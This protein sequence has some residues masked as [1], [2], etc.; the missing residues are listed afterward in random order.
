MMSI[1][2]SDVMAIIAERSDAGLFQCETVIDIR[3]GSCSFGVLFILL[4]LQCRRREPVG[5]LESALQN[6]RAAPPLP[7]IFFIP[8][9]LLLAH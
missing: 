5:R 7:A 2:R 3:Q 6:L 9:S 8:R 1:S 4:F